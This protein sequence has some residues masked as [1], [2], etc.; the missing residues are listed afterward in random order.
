MTS[1]LITRPR[2]AT[3]GPAVTHGGG[4]RRGPSERGPPA[5][6][7]PPPLVIGAG[8]D[9][10]H[11]EMRSAVTPP[12]QRPGDGSGPREAGP[13]RD[14]R[15]HFYQALSPG[16]HREGEQRPPPGG[17]GV[18]YATVIAHHNLIGVGIALFSYGD[19]VKL[20][21][22]ATAP[23]RERDEPLVPIIFHSAAAAR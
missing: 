9:T 21:G 17:D 2:P 10:T 22:S 6:G 14:D 7:L 18:N 20:P 5:P 23:Q 4:R 13:G 1:D 16:C 12:S 8:E 15:W 11:R 19:G 3:A